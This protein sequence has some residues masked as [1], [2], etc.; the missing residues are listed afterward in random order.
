MRYYQQEY[1]LIRVSTNKGTT[2]KGTYQQEYLLIG[3]STNKST[4]NNGTYQ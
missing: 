2:N 1:L 4:T 3:V